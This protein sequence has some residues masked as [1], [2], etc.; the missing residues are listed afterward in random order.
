MTN[1]GVIQHPGRSIDHL[2]FPET[3]LA[4]IMVYAG[5]TKIEVGIVGYEGMTGVPRVLGA[6]TGPFEIIVQVPGEARRIGAEALRRAMKQ[7]ET[8]E[9]TLRLFAGVQ[10][11]Q[12]SQTALANGRCTVE[13]RLARWL[14]MAHDRLEGDEVALTH[15]FLAMML[16]VRR[17]GVTVAL[18]ML[19]G[20]KAIRARRN[21]IRVLDREMLKGS[22]GE[23]YGSTEQLY[24]DL[25]GV[26]LGTRLPAGH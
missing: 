26:T 4:S 9:E 17:P 13:Q 16:G 6:P 3:G 10:L 19:E 12:F 22:A 25:F 1:R 14:L 7:S 15:E 5:S 21:S 18:H 24:R 8:I 20:M 11:V 2:Y 23:F